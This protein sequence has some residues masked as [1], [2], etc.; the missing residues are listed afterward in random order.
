MANDSLYD[1]LVFVSNMQ[2]ELDLC[3][4]QFANIFLNVTSD[5]FQ[6]AFKSGREHPGFE[7]AYKFLSFMH[8][9]HPEIMEEWRNANKK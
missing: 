7:E 5:S 8:Q 9:S 3:R 2:R 6:K 4:S 1:S